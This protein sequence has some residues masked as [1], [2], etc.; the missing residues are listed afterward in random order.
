MTRRRLAATI[1]VAVLAFFLLFAGGVQLSKS[2]SFQF[3]GGLI[4]RVETA[5]PVVALT[6]DDGPTAAGVDAVLPI[7]ESH[8]ARSTFFLIGAEVAAHPELAARIRAA[9]HELGN[10]S[11]SHKRMVFKSQRFI[12]H[13]IESTDAVLRN[14]GQEHPIHFR[15]PYGKKLLGLPWY[16]R[17]NGRP[18]ILWDIEPETDP[19]T[20][21]SA[22]AIVDH[23]LDRV[24]PGS[25][26]LLH[27]MYGSRATL[28]A[29]P[30]ILA[31][32]RARGLSAVTVSD[33]LSRQP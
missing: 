15:P 4:P 31:G 18:T 14:A 16:L 8:G 11:Y 30:G 19:A 32:L 22:D 26:I 27:P 28:D 9:G 10:H 23:V 17:K 6:F 13:E 12:A 29:L 2:R 33:L 7:L 24:R 3:F 5:R 25:I 1:F 21:K 20:A